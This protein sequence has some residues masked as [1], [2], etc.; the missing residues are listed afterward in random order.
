MCKHCSLCGT[1][2]VRVCLGS[3]ELRLHQSWLREAHR[4]PRHIFSFVSRAFYGWELEMD[5]G[6]IAT[7]QKSAGAPHQGLFSLTLESWLLTFTSIVPWSAHSEPGRTCPAVSRGSGLSVHLSAPPLSAAPQ[8]PGLSGCNE[9][10]TGLL[11]AFLCCH[12]LSTC[13]GLPGRRS[14]VPA[15]HTP[16][17]TRAML[18]PLWK[19]DNLWSLSSSQVTLCECHLDRTSTA[20]RNTALCH[21]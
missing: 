12:A 9:C 20:G 4:S 17:F 11:S 8:G 19:S 1:G 5:C 14:W 6:E 16:G 21:R 13:W 18:V 3:G 7:S 2:C 15:S 10:C